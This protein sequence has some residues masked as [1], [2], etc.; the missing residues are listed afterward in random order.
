MT[1]QSHSR[2]RDCMLVARLDATGGYA[3][4]KA[5]GQ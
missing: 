5:A 3:S 2:P 1:A 4:G